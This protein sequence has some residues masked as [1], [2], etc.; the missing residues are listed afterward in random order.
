MPMVCDAVREAGRN[1]G[2]PRAQA[3]RLGGFLFSRAV[4]VSRGPSPFKSQ[5][6]SSLTVLQA[7]FFSR[8]RKR[9]ID[10]LHTFVPRRRRNSAMVKEVRVTAQDEASASRLK[11]PRLG[12]CSGQ[13]PLPTPLSPALFTL[14]PND[15]FTKLL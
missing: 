10:V 8:F 1:E 3:L 2:H 13:R 4:S 15:R 14:T 11:R 9:E 12:P 6:Q 7:S 5:F